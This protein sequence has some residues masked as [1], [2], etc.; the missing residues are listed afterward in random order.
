MPKVAVVATQT[1]RWSRRLTEVGF[2]NS[3]LTLREALAGEADLYLV[4]GGAC[5]SDAESIVRT[6]LE[7]DGDAKKPVLFGTSLNDPGTVVDLLDAPLA[8]IV[9]AGQSPDQLRK[10]VNAALGGND[11]NGDSPT[12]AAVALATDLTRLAGRFQSEHERSKKL[13]RELNQSEGVY[14]S[15][16]NTLPV[17][18]LRKDLDC[19]FT[20]ANEPCCE[21]FELPLEKLVGKTDFD[22]F[23]AELSEKYR[24]DDL[25]VIETGKVFEDIEQY[26]AADGSDAFVHVL[27]SPVR[28]TQ[29][30][31]IG[32]QCI[33][34]DVTERVRAQSDLKQS[35]AQARAVLDSSLDCII[36]SDEHGRIVEF[37]RAAERTFGYRRD[38]AVGQPMDEL[39][40]APSSQGRGRSNLE[41]YAHH[42]EE[43]SLIGKRREVPLV[44]KSGESFIAEMA[45]QPI[46]FEVGDGNRDSPAAKQTVQFATVLHDITRRKQGELALKQAKEQAESANQ[47][48]SAFLA[49]MSH[50]IRTPMNAIIGMT[51]LVLDSDLSPEQREHLNIVQDSAESLLSLINDI[52]DFSKIEAGKLDLDRQRF[53]LRDRLGDTMKSLAMRAHAK[54]LELACHVDLQVP[55]VVEGDAGRLRQVIVN[56]VGNAIKFTEQGEVVLDVKPADGPAGD[57]S[58]G[59]V[60]LRFA[61]SDTGIGIPEDRQA[62]I[63]DAFEQADTSTTRRFGGTGLGL[64][65]SSRLV[66]LMGGGVELTSEPDK[67]ST[68]AFEAD[69]GVVDEAAARPQLETLRG[70]KVLVVDDNETNRLILREMLDNWGMRVDTAPDASQALKT[71]QAASDDGEPYPLILTDSQMPDVD[72]FS[73]VEQLRELAG[74]AAA[75][76]I[77]MLTSGDRPGDIDRSREL[78]IARFMTKPVKQSEL[79]DAIAMAFDV[80]A[81]PA[82]SDDE[83]DVDVIRGLRILLAED[84]VPNQKLAVGLLRRHDHEIVIANNGREAVE[85]S[86]AERFDII[87]MD[88]QMPEL[89]GLAATKQIRKRER[90]AGDGQHLPIVAMTAHAMKGDRD[91]CLS[92]GMD[93]YVSKPIR[94]AKLYQT[95][96]SL[97][98]ERSAADAV[99]KD[100]SPTHAAAEP[101]PASAKTV[102]ASPKPTKP[103]NDSTFESSVFDMEDAEP[104]SLLSDDSIPVFVDPT[105]S[106]VNIDT[107][108]ETVGGDRELFAEIV[109]AFNEEAPRMTAA[110]K[111][112]VRNDDAKEARRAAHTLKGNLRALGA[113]QV[114]HTAADL[115]ERAAQGDLLDMM[116][117]A[118]TLARQVKE[119]QSELQDHLGQT[120]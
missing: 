56:L 66:T 94:P 50:E 39:L 47:A 54:G 18:L 81:G 45:M 80:K 43:G 16:V 67:G 63:F 120:A 62:A 20:F 73:M 59:A 4:D 14:H 38:E 88:V 114:M 108:M 110:L 104:A 19:R 89:D 113:I 40:F 5:G 100:A 74:E 48:K 1:S 55:E 76:T 117:D 58:G 27:K 68:F 2:R 57:P 106:H 41:R 34:W 109:D 75:P 98:G 95:L 30:R 49:N 82:R 115:E 37:N 92:S 23:P 46:T 118:E 65:I 87:L 53:R 85:K 9:S 83:E 97:L 107:A 78:G 31:T 105:T 21:T 112:A 24:R 13:Q 93:G 8:G 52:L 15:L 51:G 28:D 29:G 64:A 61:V 119:V 102:G 79:H 101:K 69:L 84:S 11:A 96:R 70:L 10:T 91:L 44:K 36:L 17:N 32:V 71:L 26:Q 35:E 72:G 42:R 90:A 3:V 60:R 99:P 111:S 22:I 77:L 12:A 86:A 33:F 6:L 7:S 103:S 25:G 116:G